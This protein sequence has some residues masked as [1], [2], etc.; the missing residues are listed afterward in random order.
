MT[1]PLDPAA[2]E[3]LGWRERQG[4]YTAHEIL[5][6]YRLTADGRVVGGSRFIRYAYDGRPLPDVD[7][8][9][10]GRL[11]DIFRRRFPE[12]GPIRIA[13]HWGGPIGFALDFL[14]HVGRGGPHR[15]VLYAIG[16]AGHGVA[17]ASY[18]GRMIADLLLEREGPGAALWTRR[19]VPLPPEPLR[20]GVATAL[21][22][23]FEW[24]DRRAG[25]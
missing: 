1:E 19:H 17:L 18:A 4:V 8:G 24:M 23:L 14:P 21:I 6:S 22:G 10:A 3:A 25:G 12:L 16:Y 7:P 13:R 2:R 11:E 5:E 9:I 15:N 20:W